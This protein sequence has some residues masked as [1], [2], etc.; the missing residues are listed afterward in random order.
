MSDKSR[1]ILDTNAVIISWIIWPKSMA[2]RAVRFAVDT[3]RVL[4]S[5]ATMTELADVLSRR[6][7]D[8]YVTVEERQTFFRLFYGAVDLVLSYPSFGPAGVPRMTGSWSLLSVAGSE[9]S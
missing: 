1:V 2:G 8:A 3:T 5:E 7:F 9:I 4:A 6:K